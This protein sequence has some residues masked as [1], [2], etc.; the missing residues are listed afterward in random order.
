M[1]V[2]NEKQK[3]QKPKINNSSGKIDDF[4]KCEDH[5]YSDGEGT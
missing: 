1:L 3:Y 5:E 2:H 4:I